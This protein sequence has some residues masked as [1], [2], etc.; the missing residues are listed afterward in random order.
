[1]FFNIPGQNQETDVWQWNAMS[2]TYKTNIHWTTG[3]LIL[4]TCP[5]L[6]GLRSLR[7]KSRGEGEDVHSLFL[8]LCRVTTLEAQPPLSQDRCQLLFYRSTYT[9]KHQ[10]LA[11]V[12][13]LGQYQKKKAVILWLQIL[14]RAHSSHL[15]C[16]YFTRREFLCIGSVPAMQAAFPLLAN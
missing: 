11:L 12:I 14:L 7:V 3:K 9:Q 8:N 4:F 15:L 5:F 2:L 13:I 6:R 1:M 10:G 16:S